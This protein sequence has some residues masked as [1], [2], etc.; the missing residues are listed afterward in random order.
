MIG[1]MPD[2]LQTGRRA[3]ERS[4]AL[5]HLAGRLESGLGLT[6]RLSQWLRAAAFDAIA[7]GV[8]PADARLL[9]ASRSDRL[10]SA[11][12]RVLLDRLLA[13]RE[14]L[15]VRRTPPAAGG[16]MG[17]ALLITGPSLYGR[18]A[19]ML[20][21][22]GIQAFL[23]ES[24]ARAPDRARET[25]PDVVLIA[26]RLEDGDGLSVGR[27]LRDNEAL[28]SVAVHDLRLGGDEREASAAIDAGF[29]DTF[30]LLQLPSYFPDMMRT[31]VV[32]RHRCLGASLGDPTP[33][34]IAAG[35]Y[36]IE[37]QLG[38]GGAGK[39]YKVMDLRCGTQR[40]LKILRGALDH[41]PLAERRFE[42]EIAALGELDHPRVIRLFDSGLLHGR[43][44]YTMEYFPA[45]SLH[46]RLD[47][48]ESFSPREAALDL[49]AI[50]DGLAAAH[51][52]GILH[53]DIKADNILYRHRGDPVLTDFGLATG[54]GRGPRLTASGFVVGTP[55]YMSP[56][57]I[58]RAGRVDERSDLFGLGILLF[59]MLVGDLP[60]H[61]RDTHELLSATL[62]G[63]LDELESFRPGLPSGFGTLYRRLT[64]VQPEQR[65][66]SA[67]RVAE[68]ARRLAS[69][70]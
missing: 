42:G 4:D 9:R 64:A 48:G 13:V 21:G 10:S 36:R 50:A 57:Q 30:D 23:E 69:S 67:K 49:A 2:E 68:V 65:Y 8:L 56:E 33:G 35:R 26:R 1:A 55:G 62:D 15:A 54:P 59:E 12:A 46:S 24:S 44:F 25:A 43:P 47:R 60:I 5:E 37:Q 31:R 34:A 20:E 18:L 11:S 14:Q 58:R 7:A 39:V 66:R 28:S 52:R 53:R 6:D 51:R 63:R 27:T 70:V 38:A 19:P 61:G 22:V 45:G 17:R 16:F 41:D 29:D 3:T 32:R 40:A